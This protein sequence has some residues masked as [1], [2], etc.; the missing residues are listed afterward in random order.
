MKKAI[1]TL[2]LFVALSL[3]VAFSTPLAA[4]TFT[5]IS[6]G[7]WHDDATWDLG[8]VPGIADH[9]VIDGHVVTFS[10]LSGTLSVGSIE[11]SN[12]TGTGDS[13]LYI[14]GGS[15]TVEGNLDAI[16]V[17]E[18]RV[19]E[20][21]IKNDA[22]VRV[23]GKVEYSRDNANAHNE[24]LRLRMDGTSSLTVDSTFTYYYGDAVGE[25]GIDINIAD[26]SVLEIK[27]DAYLYLINGGALTMSVANRAS[28][29]VGGNFVMQQ[30]GGSYLTFSASDDADVHFKANV[31]MITS[32]GWD[33]IFSTWGQ[34]Y[35][36]IDSSLILSS[37]VSG[38]DV[39]VNT[40]GSESS[41]EVK[42]DI[43]MSAVGAGDVDINM[44]GG[45]SLFLGGNFSRPT[46]FG[47]LRMAANSQLSYNGIRAQ[48]IARDELAG[49]DT[50]K[51]EYTN[52]IFDNTSGFP[53][54][55]EGPMVIADSLV[56]TNGIIQT[57]TVN[58]LTIAD[59]ATISGG[60]TNAYISGPI[61]KEGS[62]NGGSFIFPVGGGGTYA[63]IEIGALANASDSYTA[64]YFNCPPPFGNNLA[65]GLS[66]I[67]NSEYWTLEKGTGTPDVSVRLHWNDADARGIDDLSSLVVASYNRGSSEWMS[68]GN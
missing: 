6:N 41:V 43:V 27:Q 12:A 25:L 67:S 55:L 13:Y 15:L 5:A 47:R 10:S 49:A 59:G 9:A 66:H 31:S 22:Q 7:D 16:A 44:T 58:T 61:T 24:R 35:I 23:K 39:S 53:L 48:T 62:T 45:G 17:N 26:T 14:T 65:V 4:A 54:S 68:L 34:A 46:N 50:D 28:V 29:T 20:L 30:S 32:G 3:F 11:I 56:L 18:G 40:N 51:F 57:D 42:G 36:T 33:N 8:S 1:Q 37:T 19:V 2:Q 60:S 38:E 52:V 63:P 64:R 21:S